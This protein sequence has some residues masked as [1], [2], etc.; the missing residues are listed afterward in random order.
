MDIFLEELQAKLQERQQN[1][2]DYGF[3]QAIEY[4]GLHNHTLMIYD[5][6]HS[7][8]FKQERKKF[9]TNPKYDKLLEQDPRE[10]PGDRLH[11][12]FL[13]IQ[14]RYNN[15]RKYLLDNF[16]TLDKFSPDHLHKFHELLCEHAEVL[17]Y[18]DTHR[19]SFTLN[20]T[21]PDLFKKV[22]DGYN[23]VMDPDNNEL[24][25]F[26]DVMNGVWTL[27]HLNLPHEALVILNKVG[28]NFDLFL[29]GQEDSIFIF[30]NTE[31]HI[32]RMAQ[33]L[34]WAFAWAY[35]QLGNDDVSAFYL[36]QIL[37]RHPK[38][39]ESGPMQIFWHTGC[40]RILE[41]AVELYKLEPTEENKTEIL[42]IIQYNYTKDCHE[43]NE[44][45]REMLYAIWSASRTLFN[46]P[47]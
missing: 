2:E 10:I 11:E 21:G 36:K 26:Q 4:K 18:F 20:R 13:D 30:T 27:I 14:L 12:Y 6:Y 43:P 7:D 5:L 34:D 28:I 37:T 1:K 3:K 45:L 15:H 31:A 22:I 32:P 44:S 40:A 8:F 19:F 41:A 9:I 17:S 16:N 46:K 47:L 38:N 42:D 23:Y 35:R 24:V 33:S 39:M 25:Y 29:R